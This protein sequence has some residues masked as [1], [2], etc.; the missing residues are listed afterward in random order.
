MQKWIESMTPGDPHRWLAQRA[1]DW[2]VDTKQWLAPDAPPFENTQICSYE[3]VLGGRYIL[4]K[5]QESD[6]GGMPFGGLGFI[7]FDNVRQIYVNSWIDSFG[8][9]IATGEGS[10][11]DGVL[12]WNYISS[13]PISGNKMQWRG[14]EQE[15]SVDE[16]VITYFN[17]KPDGTEAKHMVQHARRIKKSDGKKTDNSD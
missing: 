1:G 4:Q 13:D 9:G 3:V 5:V 12:T 7:G 2:E 6:W 14:T 17:K 8:T 11:K 15:I 16:F 10:R